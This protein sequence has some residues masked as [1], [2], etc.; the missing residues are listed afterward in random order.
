MKKS[1]E[2]K[3]VLPSQFYAAIKR[4][5]EAFLSTRMEF[6]SKNICCYGGKKARIERVS[7]C[8]PK[9]IS[10]NYPFKRLK[11]KKTKPKNT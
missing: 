8:A 7:Y 2:S 9:G 10:I 5:Q 6:S 11:K 4:M 1:E 3:R